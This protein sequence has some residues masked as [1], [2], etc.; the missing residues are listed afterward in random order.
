MR[1]LGCMFSRIDF[2]CMPHE[3]FAVTN[4]SIITQIANGLM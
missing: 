4:L 2:V 3:G 1:T